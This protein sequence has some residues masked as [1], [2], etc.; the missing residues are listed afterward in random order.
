MTSHPV[1]LEESIDDDPCLASA[2]DGA[3]NTLAEESQV[4]TQTS[5]NDVRYS[6]RPPSLCVFMHWTVEDSYGMWQDFR[7]QFA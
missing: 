1:N 2:L 5:R 3:S 7:S 4:E 6:L